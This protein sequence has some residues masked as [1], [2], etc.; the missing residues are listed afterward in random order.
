MTTLTLELFLAISGIFAGTL[1]AL[2]VMILSKLG[3]ISENVVVMATPVK[4]IE[5]FLIQLG[6]EAFKR[7]PSMDRKTELLQKMEQRVL[8]SF[9][10]EEL[11]AIIQQETAAAKAGNDFLKLLGGLAILALL[12]A[13]IGESEDK[14]KRRRR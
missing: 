8:T 13:I 12:A 7:N 6:M 11:R 2:L 3:S 1:I 9:E 14:K 4:A 10:A 5:N